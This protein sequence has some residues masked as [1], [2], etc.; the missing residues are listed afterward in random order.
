MKKNATKRQ[1]RRKGTP[2]PRLRGRGDY[3]AEVS[4]IKLPLPRLE[5]KIDHLERSLVHTTPKLTRAAST[6]GRTLGNFLNQGDLGAAAGEGLA[7][8]FGHGDYT[9]KANS[10]VHGVNGPTVPKFAGNGK[11][12]TRI[13]ERE[14][15]TDVF[16]GAL[17]AG[18][19]AFTN[20]TYRI[21]P[22]DSNVFPWLAAIAS[23][24]DQWDPHGIVFE[25]IST[26]STFNGTSQALGTVVMATDYD[27]TDTAYASKQ[28]ME[29]ADF[30]CSSKPSESLL[31]GI[32]CE[33]TERPTK[34]LYTSSPANPLFADL[35][36]FQLATAGCSTA[37][38]RLGEL[39]VS[40]DITFYKKQVAS[41]AVTLP[42]YSAPGTAFA[43]SA[44]FGSPVGATSLGIT[45][46][47]AAAS[48][49]ITLPPGLGNGRFIMCYSLTTFSAADN[50][51]VF[52]F[53]NCVQSSYRGSTDASPQT[54]V[55]QVDITAPGATIAVTGT[56]TV[57]TSACFLMVTMVPLTLFF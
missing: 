57:T 28:Q 53:T 54:F 55:L 9:L 27:V 34:V 47:S 32:E 15:I 3:S 46:A 4:G 12:G 25:F 39:W 30:S 44:Y 38:A 43:G 8:L 33:P 56:K 52:V 11:R 5:A 31:H 37:G 22:T 29:N 50:P 42:F 21:N 45:V 14:F 20:T 51:D 35:G 23:Q 48:Y 16:S 13:T 7:K 17:S 1:P 2:T 26:S 24:F 19:S 36:N 40:Y 10:L 6:I 18:A 49:T 41:P